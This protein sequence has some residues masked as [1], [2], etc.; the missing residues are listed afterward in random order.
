MI[1]EFL[2]YPSYYIFIIIFFIN[3][4][5]TM[6]IIPPLIKFAPKIGLI[7]YPNGHKIHMYPKPS[8]GG[9]AIVTTFIITS[10]LFIPLKGL[11]GF[12]LGFIIIFIAGLLDDSKDLNPYLKFSFQVFA[13]FFAVYF[14][15]IKIKTIG[16]LIGVGDINLG[17]FSTIF[18]MFCIVGVVNA[19]NM[20]DGLDGL[21]GSISSI[22]LAYFAILAYINGQ[23]EI[24]L[25]SISL[26]GVIMGFLKYNW[27]PAK[28]F[29]GDSGSLP[30][31]FVLAYISIALTQ[32][33]NSRVPPVVPLIIL[34]LPIVDTI[35]LIIKR[36][37]R[38]QNPFRADKSHI[39]HNL[40]KLGLN[41][42]KSVISLLIV[43]AVFSIFSITGTL[44]KIPDYY[45]FMVFVFFF[46]V[47]FV[48]S[49]NFEI[50]Q[51]FIA[52]V[53]LSNKGFKKR[54]MYVCYLFDS[55]F[56]IRRKERRYYINLSF[57]ITKNGNNQI[58]DGG[59]VNI[60][61]GGLST[62]LK[63]LLVRGEKTNVLLSLPQLN[64]CKSHSIV[65]IAEVI[66]VKKNGQ[67]YRYGMRFLT[68]LKHHRLLRESLV[69]V[70]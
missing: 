41:K 63:E 23:V 15:D 53:E 12:F 70:I 30:I 49:F 32:T 60:S 11:Y 52:N 50:I 22:A 5:I 21:V 26:M 8:I 64:S 16:D 67:C 65:T 46:L 45:F 37:A 10:F 47:Y 3:L 20:M 31:G 56:K 7:D 54:I 58:L 6:I 40:L 29:M 68:N 1:K 13:V 59:L 44:L 17:V 57:K 28:I 38:H 9:L 18:T 43:T 55:I 14:S 4:A 61:A 2:I 25:I 35:T 33:S 51:N 39:H 19:I 27:H 69:A 36:I 62:E 48:F 66:W 42:S 24:V 34:S